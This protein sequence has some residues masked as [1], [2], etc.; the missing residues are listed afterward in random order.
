VARAIL[1]L[2]DLAR[3]DH[4]TCA[5]RA[6]EPTAGSLALDRDGGAS[7]ERCARNIYVFRNGTRRPFVTGAVTAR[8]FRHEG[9][10]VVLT[11]SQRSLIHVSD[12]TESDQQQ[13]RFRPVTW[14]ALCGIGAAS[15]RRKSEEPPLLLPI[16]RQIPGEHY[17]PGGRQLDGLLADQDRANDVRREIRETTSTAT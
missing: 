9:V 12:V 10:A 1:W 15:G 2:P 7:D 4:F 11:G 17:E 16:V 8:R 6:G 14:R 5:S 13:V 3:E